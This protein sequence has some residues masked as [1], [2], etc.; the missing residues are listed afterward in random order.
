M[1]DLL[2]VFC[3]IIAWKGDDR[4]STRLAAQGTSTRGAIDLSQGPM[5]PRQGPRLT[6]GSQTGEQTPQ[7]V[8]FQLSG[9]IFQSKKILH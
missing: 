1:K 4:S 3:L 6:L 9:S 8:V 5:A 2:L 7:K